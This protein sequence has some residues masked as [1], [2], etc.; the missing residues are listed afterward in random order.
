MKRQSEVITVMD[1]IGTSHATLPAFGEIIYEAAKQQMER[2]ECVTLDFTGIK[3]TTDSFLK[4]SIGSLILLAPENKTL[5]KVKGL[6]NGKWR[7]E[8]KNVITHALSPQEK[9]NS[10]EKLNGLFTD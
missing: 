9:I 3:K 7:E 2:K 1:L 5:L 8:V 6:A 10:Q 4:A